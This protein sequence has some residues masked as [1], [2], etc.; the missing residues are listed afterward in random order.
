MNPADTTPGIAETRSRI[1]GI[2]AADRAIA[3][4]AQPAF[5]ESN[6][7]Q[8]SI[9][10]TLRGSRPM[11]TF[12]TRTKLDRKSP[13]PMVSTTASAIS[14]T[15]S[16][17][18]RRV[19]PAVALRLPSRRAIALPE[20]ESCSAGA[21]PKSSPVTRAAAAATPSTRRSSATVEIRRQRLGQ[22]GAKHVD[23]PDR[24]DQPQERAGCRKH[25][26]LEEQ[27]APAI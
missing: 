3:G 2:S 21:S 7:G 20:R 4:S 12:A 15:T 26:A 6:L 17:D 27:A 9:V 19:P 23:A 5:D 13:A 1:S 11:S 25:Q 24:D 22:R 8:T 10:S 18:R 14:E 16:T